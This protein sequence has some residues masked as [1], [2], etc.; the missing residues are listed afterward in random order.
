MDT[1]AIAAELKDIIRDA[2][3]NAPR[4]LQRQIGPSEVGTGC[5]QKLAR[6]LLDWPAVNPGGDPLPSIDGTAFHA[7]VAE[8]F[9]RHNGQY[10]GAAVA[11]RWLVETRLEIAP[12][13][14]GSCDL[15]RL[16]VETNTLDVLDWKR[17]SPRV[18]AKY[19]KDGLPPEYQ[20]QPHLY[21]MG[22]ERLGYVVR[23][24]ALVFIPRG[25][26]LEDM[27][28]HTEPYSREKAQ[29]ALNRM[30]S[31]RQALIAVDPETKPDMWSVFPAAPSHMCTYCPYYKPGTTD[32]S[33]G[34][35]SEP[36]AVTPRRSMESLIA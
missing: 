36:D 2:A 6:K 3:A 5:T 18:I 16:E 27:W 7:W 10:G 4:S 35:P 12:G 13:L 17:S 15:G 8:A 11:A 24:V 20:A 9:E 21:G 31:V 29:A 33:L 23:N 34:C 22:F 28:I 30:E 14:A 19:R 32:L 26:R 1:E 25:G